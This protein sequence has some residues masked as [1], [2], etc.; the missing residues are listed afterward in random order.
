MGLELRW[1]A[2]TDP[3]RVRVVN[4]DSAH[5]EESLWVVADGMG[6]HAAGD[7]ASRI[8]VD[9]LRENAAE[10]GLVEAVRLA[11][12]AVLEQADRDSALRGMGTTV[13]AAAPVEIDGVTQLQVVNVGDSRA[14][15]FRDGELH[16]LT[17][18]H[19]LVAELEREGRITAA[20]A[21]THPRRNIVTRVLGNEFDVEVDSFP[22]DP[23]KGDRLVLCSDGLFNEIDDRD[24]IGVLAHE[25]D[26]VAAAGALVD[27]ANRAGGRDNIT[28]VVVDVVDDGDKAATASAR[29][30]ED[31][32]LARTGSSPALAPPPAD[33]DR[34]GRGGTAAAAAV[35]TPPAPTHRRFTWRVAI[36]LGAI[37]VV[38]L[39][40]LGGT[41]WVA[42]STYYVGLSGNNVVVFRGRPGGVLFLDPTVEENTNLTLA[43]VP[44]SQVDAVKAGKTAATLAQARAYVAN[45]RTEQ[46]A[47]Q[48]ASGTTT[49]T[50][51]GAAA[52]SPDA[53]TTSTT[54]VGG[55]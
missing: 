29:L 35:E 33:E 9:S 22:V 4:E 19:S 13:T 10:V 21:R 30:A 12:R 52:T 15:L 6:G 20:E 5:A 48:A 32:L 2:A 49:T 43:D 46:A 44:P 45:L 1:G 41:W 23:F 14:Y 51:A 55:P 18:D 27:L 28:V 34:D 25:R 36:F 38:V 8:A 54:T 37:V 7:V 11:N 40:A 50:A 53:G 16:Q 24:I 39:V 17:E 47:D 42:R 3:G 26:P 31:P